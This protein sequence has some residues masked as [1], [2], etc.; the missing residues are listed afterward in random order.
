MLQLENQTPFKATFAVLPDRAGIDTL[1][2]IIKAT[3]NL[4]PALSL[5]DVQVPPTLADEYYEDPAVSSL[6]YG[7][8]M[9]IGKLGTDVLLIGRAWAPDKRPVQRMQVGMRVAERQKLILVTGDRVWQD[10]VPSSPQPFES[11]PL[12]WE[13]AFGGIHRDG[14]TVAAE[15]RNPVGCGFAGGRSASAMQGLPVPNLEDPAAPLQQVGQ[16]ANP[17][18]L[19]PIAPSWLPRRAYAG[20]Y[21]ERWQRSRAPYLPDDFDPRFFQAAVPEFSFDRYLQP[22]EQVHAVGVTPDGPILFAI[23]D[24]L[25]SVTVTVA[26][27]AQAP[28][29]NLETLSIEPDENRAC[30]TWRAAVPCDRKALKVEKIVVSRAGPRS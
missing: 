2:V 5:A 28:D 29:V 10:G 18:C 4:R 15:E 30:F 26:G 24:S 7:T 23:P 11:M 27:A 8:E 22:G 13:R 25:L 9:H 16:A 17:A 1:Y 20:T 14:D 3:V 21:D 19:A 12:I 6:R